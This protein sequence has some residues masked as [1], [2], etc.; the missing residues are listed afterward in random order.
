MKVI[1]YIK[2]RKYLILI[3]L[4]SYIILITSGT[5]AYLYTSSKNSNL[6]GNMATANLDLKVTRVTP[7]ESSGT[8]NLVPLLDA[9][10]KN[11]LKGNGGVS[12]CVDA[13]RNVSCE[14]YKITIHNTGSSNL[15]LSGFITLVASGQDNI[16]NNLKWELIE[17][18]TT[19][20]T[21]YVTNNMEKSVIEKNLT[22]QSN[23]T[24]DYYIALWISENGRDQRQTDTGVYGGLIEFNTSNGLGTTAT[25]GEF[26][27]DYCTNNKITKLSDCLFIS[28]KFASSVD[29][30]K[31]E[32]ES[33]KANFN[34]T[35]PMITYTKT[36]ALNLQGSNLV[37]TTDK[38]YFGTSYTFNAS[39]GQYT[40]QSTSRDNMTDKLSAT[41][42]KYY[43]CVNTNTSCSTMYVIYTATS[44][45]SGTTTTYK[46]TKVDQYSSEK[47]VV[48]LSNSGLYMT[49][50]DY[51]KSYY[52]RG[53]VENNYVSFAGFIWRIVRINGDGSIRMIYSGTSTTDTGAKTSIGTSAFN[54]DPYDPAMVGYKYGLDKTYQET[55]ATNLNY[56]NINANKIYY[57][58]DSYTKNDTIKKLSLSGNLTSG[59]LENVWGSNNS[60]YK[61]TCF[62]T[63][64][65]G[66]CTTLVEIASYVNI[67]RVKV[68]A[69]HSYL[70]KSYESTY[71]DEHDSTIK[72]KIDAWYKTNIQDKGYSTYLTDNLFCNDRSIFSGD[73]FSLNQ[74]TYYGA[75]NRNVDHKTPSYK[76]PRQK[77]QFTTS[78]GTT[79][80]N[81]ELTYP[82]GL[83]TADEVAYAGGKQGYD[84]K[85]YYLATGQYYWLA[86]PSCFISWDAFARGWIAYPSGYLTPWAWVSSSFGVRP[87][88]NLNADVLLSEGNGTTS[89][90]YI[91][92]VD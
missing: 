33:R 19:R 15:K 1:E 55:T 21:E 68:K 2:K 90:P 16:Y 56:N 75:Y 35:A 13:N 48:N 69:Y 92:K 53:R 79:L 6:A 41:D 86:S 87:V 36:S 88:I 34:E 58:A 71:T 20:K 23:E 74:T 60:T 39:T 57:F 67:S 81:G 25:F 82:V 46:A 11:A 29:D 49:E 78:S 4:F 7:S 27:S 12:S 28:D 83:L 5:Y 70:S 89:N 10:L 64:S 38:I 9:A 50:D 47:N 44:T 22:I 8:S 85:E 37:S 52:Y 43:T 80:G 54:T 3:A 62:S 40:L 42:K 76:C 17:N 32:I 72:T 51:G 26:D 63:S 61:Y 73:G 84:N 18:A 30:A 14:V 59:T 66:T 31:T 65:T 45:T 77:D 24:K 91:V